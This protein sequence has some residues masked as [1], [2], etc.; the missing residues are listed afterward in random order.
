LN[1]PEDIRYRPEFMWL[2]II[3]RPHEPDHDQLN[4]YVRPIVDDFVAGWTRGFRVSRTALHPL[5]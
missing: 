4:Y 3:V 5:G 2:S 1:L